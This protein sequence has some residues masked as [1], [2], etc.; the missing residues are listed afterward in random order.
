MKKRWLWLVVSGVCLL[1]IA[2][3]GLYRGISGQSDV[4]RVPGWI[5]FVAGLVFG[6]GSLIVGTRERRTARESSSEELL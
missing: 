4:Q 2:V 5:F 1:L 3:G 6:V